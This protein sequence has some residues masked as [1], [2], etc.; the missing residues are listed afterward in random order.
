M[1]IYGGPDIETDGLILRLQAANNKSYI[2]S[3]TSWKDLSG[4]AR[5]FTL[6]NSPT[7]STTRKGKFIFG[8]TNQYASYA[9]PI[10][11]N[12]DQFTW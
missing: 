12:R 10:L 5:N 9:Q 1:T 8:G 3:G 6:V 7:F 2:G 4:N 11:V